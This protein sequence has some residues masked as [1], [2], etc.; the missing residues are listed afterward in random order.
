MSL[1]IDLQIK[2]TIHTHIVSISL[3]KI[4]IFIFS[5]FPTF[6]NAMDVNT[7]ELFNPASAVYDVTNTAPNTIKTMQL[8]E[9]TLVQVDAI[10]GLMPR[11]I[12]LGACSE[13][14]CPIDAV[15]CDAVTEL[16]SCPSGSVLNATRDMCQKDPDVFECPSGFNYDNMLG[17]C[18]KPLECPSGGEYNVSRNRCEFKRIYECPVGYTQ[19]GNTCVAP[20]TC[21]SN[22]IFNP[23]TLKCE[24]DATYACADAGW[25]YEAATNKCWLAPPTCP[26]GYVYNT[27]YDKC[28]LAYTKG[29]ASGYTY[30]TTRTRCEKTPPDCPSGT[31]YNT[32]TNRCE[33]G[34]GSACTLSGGTWNGS[35]CTV[36]GSYAAAV[37]STGNRIFSWYISPTLGANT[38]IKRYPFTGLPLPEKPISVVYNRAAGQG[39]F[40]GISPA[41][42]SLL[43]SE[44]T[45]FSATYDDAVD[46]V[47]IN[48]N[49][50]TGEVYFDYFLQNNSTLV[51][52]YAST[53]TYTCPSGGTLSGTTCNTTSNVAAS[54]PVGY[55]H[56]G[57]GKCYANPTCPSSGSFDGNLDL[58]YV[59]FTKTCSSGTYD[60]SVD[61]CVQNATC[62]KGVLNPSKDRCEQDY[63]PVCGTGWTFNSATQFCEKLPVC[64]TGVYSNT[65]DKCLLSYVPSCTSGYTYN[66][67]RDRCEKNPPDCPNG[68]TYNETT[69]RCEQGAGSACTLAGGTWNGTDCT[70]D[71][72]Y[73][74]TSVMSCPTKIFYR[75]VKTPSEF[76]TDSSEWSWYALSTLTLKTE[77]AT[78]C[79]YEGLYAPRPTIQI[80]AVSPKTSVGGCPTI[81]LRNGGLGAWTLSATYQYITPNINTTGAVFATSYG[82]GTN[83]VCFSDIG[84]SVGDF[85]Y[86]T[87]LFVFN[88]CPSGGTLSGTTCNTTSNVAASCP[89]GYTHDGSGRCY[90]N[91]TCPSSGSFDGVNDIC[92]L[93]FGKSC[94][95]GS[96]DTISNACV[97]DPI[98]DEG[99][100]N[101]T[102]DKCQLSRD[103]VCSI[104]AKDLVTGKC[105]FVASCQSN[106]TLV[107]DKC[108]NYPIPLTCPSG[109]DTTLDVCYSN[110]NDCYVDNSYI[111]ANTLAY[112]ASLKTC[113]V[114]EKIACATGLTWS[115][116]YIKCEAVPICYN[117]MYNPE[118]DFCYIST[119]ECP[120]NS[121]YPCKGPIGNKWCSPYECN[122]TTN[123]CGYAK[124]SSGYPPTSK[125]EP[126]EQ[127]SGLILNT[128]DSVCMD[129]SCYF[130]NSSRISYCGTE[131]TCPKGFGVFQEGSNCYQ[132]VCPPTSQE[133]DGSCY[134]LK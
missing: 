36:S 27:T 24:L 3:L 72:S 42:I 53:T 65:Y 90:A 114:E 54:C 17:K 58:C 28:F 71:G 21:P 88:S 110:V 92:Y 116:T 79:T 64:I 132:S 69:N 2:Q 122:P 100:L 118:N 43:Y 84:R 109:T 35:T 44:G 98:C 77:T 4:F 16:P 56:D 130:S 32:A 40:A 76:S 49:Y 127:I 85:Y 57:S 70:V 41:N 89:A 107:V 8:V 59:S 128:S 63:V 38:S 108:T 75:P 112:S 129:M 33:Q 45:I 47:V 37:N 125:E 48:F 61:Q 134:E 68:T 104:G 113:L 60:S 78:N 117:G 97:L 34:S 95:S 51:I 103:V 80:K 133:L 83:Q 29:C 99:I 115:E 62:A 52:T 10:S 96:Y 101:T 46:S 105:T 91:P 55:T 5:F 66:A 1:F 12:K 121:S 119:K 50:N 86:V 111:N 82:N 7:T 25:T 120:I 18:V 81:Y 131:A 23:T 73:V 26:V 19:E 11:E 124:C 87:P 102:L 22:A 15:Q 39:W 31:T 13:T 123:Q 74:A 106:A 30:N 20:P 93:T 14:G 9:K 94:T 126:T 67:T 6:V